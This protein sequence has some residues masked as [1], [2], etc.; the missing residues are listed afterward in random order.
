[1]KRTNVVIDEKLVAQGMKV[2][3]I[4]TFKNLIDHALRE[5]VRREAQ[6]A[7]LDLKGK[8]TWNGDLNEMRTTR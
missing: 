2:T 7:I 6:L 8:I 3:G 1:M 5:L 4:K